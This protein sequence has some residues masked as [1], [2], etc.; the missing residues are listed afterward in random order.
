MVSLLGIETKRKELSK[1]EEDLKSW[2]SKKVKENAARGG[3]DPS[4]KETRS[5]KAIV[6]GTSAA[7]GSFQQIELLSDSSDEENDDM[8]DDKDLGDDIRIEEELFA[9]YACPKFVLSS[10]E[11]RRIR[12]PW[13]R[14]LIVKLMGRKIGYKALET[15]L[16][17]LWVRQGV[18]SIIID[19]SHD[20][21]LVHFTS[22]GD[23]YRALT[24]GPWMIY[25]HYL[26]VSKWSP[27]FNPA[28]NKIEKMAVWVRFSGLPIEYYDKKILNGIG[29]RIGKTVKVDKNTLLQE[30]GKYACLCVEVDL[31]KPLLAMFTIKESYDRVEYE[32][33]HQLCIT[34]GKFG[35][36]KEGCSLKSQEQ[37]K[38]RVDQPNQGDTMMNEKLALAERPWTVVKKTRRPRKPKQ[39]DGDSA[40]AKNSGNNNQGS[41]GMGS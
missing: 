5:Y 34:C 39:D 37:H 41:K 21:F 9:S 4:D 13:K 22:K 3:G 8:D 20:Y 10:R 36:V 31:T 12:K 15:R 35:H 25:D 18:I 2:S 24:E 29:N 19:L 28:K 27:D 16:K 14:G 26:S 11:E 7:S 17:Q 32:G 23:Q 6:M 40:L 1:E 30:H 38:E 33:L